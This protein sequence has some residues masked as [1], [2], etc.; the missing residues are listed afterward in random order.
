MGDPGQVEHLAEPAWLSEPIGGEKAADRIEQVADAGAAGTDVAGAAGLG[1]PNVPLAGVSVGDVAGGVLTAVAQ[2]KASTAQSAVGKGADAVGA[3]VTD[4]LFGAASTAVLGPAG[5]LVPVIDKGVEV[6]A[7]K[8]LGVPGMSI[9]ATAN[10]A[11]RGGVTAA[12]GAVTGREKGTATFTAKAETGEYGPIIKT[13]TA[14]FTGR[15]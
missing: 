7:N 9:A 11:I 6:L 13:L 5:V 1:G 3:G 4:V 10:G 15:K 12:E 14:L 2:A 8:A